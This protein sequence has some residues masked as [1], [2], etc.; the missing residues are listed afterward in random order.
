M[1]NTTSEFSSNSLYGLKKEAF[2]VQIAPDELNLPFP[3]TPVQYAYFIGR[4]KIYDL[5]GVATH[6]YFEYDYQDL[7][8]FA[9]EKVWNWL[10]QEHPMMRAVIASSGLEQRILQFVPLLQIP[11]D[12][13]S[14]L[15]KEEQNTYLSKKRKKLSHQV[16]NIHEWPP[17]DVRVTKI[18][19]NLF[20]L[21]LDFDNI[22][23]DAWSVMH[24]INMQSKLY[25]QNLPN[26]TNKNFSFRD[27]V[28]TVQKLSESTSANDSKNY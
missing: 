3:L 26:H 14:K 6:Y 10:I 12:D 23:F 20:R 15:T 21:H 25:K 8:I 1:M 17:F 2:Q 7:D 4:Q 27:Y 5:G 11:V 13:I 9:L 19:E 24:I 22:F 28:I 18:Q 16:L